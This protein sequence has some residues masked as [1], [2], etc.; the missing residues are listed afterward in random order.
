MGFVYRKPFAQ[1]RRIPVKI[2]VNCP[3]NKPED[4][5][6]PLDNCRC[7]RT[8]EDA[9]NSVSPSPEELTSH[10]NMFR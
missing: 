3:F 2:D 9:A 10:K 4:A 1:V 6:D 5:A 8:K 7:I